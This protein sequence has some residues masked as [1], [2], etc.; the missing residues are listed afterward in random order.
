MGERET[1]R[2]DANAD[3]NAQQ[4]WITASSVSR[5]PSRICHNRRPWEPKL[6]RSGYETTKSKHFFEFWVS[7][8]NV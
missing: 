7:A 8:N 2:D 4:L 5:N 3:T 6:R 1:E